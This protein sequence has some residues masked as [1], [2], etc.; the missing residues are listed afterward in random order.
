MIRDALKVMNTHAFKYKQSCFKKFIIGTRLPIYDMNIS[1]KKK[2]GICALVQ[3][4]QLVQMRM[5]FSRYAVNA[6][7]F[8][9]LRHPKTKYLASVHC[10]FRNFRLV[11]ERLAFLKMK[12]N[13]N[14]QLRDQMKH[15]KENDK[16]LFIQLNQILVSSHLQQG[17]I[18]GGFS[19]A[20]SEIF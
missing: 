11:R 9:C 15:Y 16:D 14:S 4:S 3:Y 13:L 18:E 6:K 8:K 2:R 1:K 5:H 7:L 17:G 10:I 19:Y 12:K 20:L